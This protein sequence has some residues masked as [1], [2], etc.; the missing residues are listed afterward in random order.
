MYQFAY[1]EICDEPPS[2]S[3]PKPRGLLEALELIEAAQCVSSAS[4][5]WLGVLSDFRKLWLSIVEDFPQ[6]TP[7]RVEYAPPGGALAEGVLRDIERCRFH[8]MEPRTGRS[9]Q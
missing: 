6:S 1:S 2:Q 7:D 4:H 5:E 9:L 8:Q 3:T